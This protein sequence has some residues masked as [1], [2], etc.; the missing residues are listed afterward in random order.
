MMVAALDEELQAG[1][2]NSGTISARGMIALQMIS[3]LG[4]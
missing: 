2:Y 1:R 3:T 4:H